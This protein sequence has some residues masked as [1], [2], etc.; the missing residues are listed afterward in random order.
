MHDQVAGVDQHPVGAARALDPHAARL[1]GVPAAGGADALATW[2]VP[3]MAAAFLAGRRDRAR[4]QL[5][6]PASVLLGYGMAAQI[7]PA[8]WLPLVPASVMA[9]LAMARRA[10]LLPAIAAVALPM[11]GWAAAPLARWASMGLASLTGHKTTLH[12]WPDLGDAVFRTGLPGLALLL[13]A[14]RAPMPGPAR[15]AVAALAGDALLVAAHL[16][17]KQAFAIEDARSFFQDA[18]AERTLWE[19]LLAAAAAAAGLRGG[20]GTAV[21][22]GGAGLLHTIWFTGVVADPLFVAQRVGPWLVP[23]FLVA[24]AMVWFGARAIP[25]LRRA[26]NWAL[27]G[28]AAAG[29]FMLLRQSLHAPMILDAG[30]GPAERIARSI[31]GLAL[32]GAFLAIGVKARLR[33][34]RLASLGLALATAA[35]VFL[36]DASG[37]E[38]LPRIAAFAVLGCGLIGVGW[39]YARYLPDETP[40]GGWSG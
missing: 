10:S 39:L 35:K 15:R 16:G 26:R 38:G 32:A 22:V 2:A 24:G 28:L 34:C 18:M 3:A 25:P 33:D 36:L 13:A 17:W 5:F 6:R 12:D 1:F 20:R 14:M 27:M 23:A 4:D 29:A 21:A 31:L 30:T 19:A 40:P 7:V 9:G 8:G 11:A 37:L